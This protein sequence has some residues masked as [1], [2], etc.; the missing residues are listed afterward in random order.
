M[1]VERDLCEDNLNTRTDV[2]RPR[3]CVRGKGSLVSGT[4]FGGGREFPFPDGSIVRSGNISP[5]K[6]TGTGSW[7]EEA[8]LALF[9]SRSDSSTL[10]KKLQAGEFNSIMPWTMYGKMKDDDLKAIFAFL[11]T[12]TPVNNSVVKFTPGTAKM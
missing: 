1:R 4:E 5:D 12:V 6:T 2:R 3:S 8:F 11:K 7:T 9:H 10:A